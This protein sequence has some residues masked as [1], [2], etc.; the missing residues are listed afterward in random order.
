MF[1]GYF[2]LGYQGRFRYFKTRN[3]PPSFTQLQSP[4]FHSY[5]NFEPI[6]SWMFDLENA[7]LLQTENGTIICKNMFSKKLLD[8]LASDALYEYTTQERGL[9]SD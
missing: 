9:L 7:K 5:E 2:K 4:N 8:K 6:D 3:P 1:N